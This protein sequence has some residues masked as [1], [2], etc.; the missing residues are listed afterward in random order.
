MVEAAC[1]EVRRA[2]GMAEAVRLGGGAG[3]GNGGSGAFGGD[4]VDRKGILPL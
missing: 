1:L 4:P 2:G 3:W